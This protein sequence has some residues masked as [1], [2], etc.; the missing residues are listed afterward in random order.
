M[1]IPDYGENVYNIVSDIVGLKFKAQI[2]GSGIALKGIYKI[3]NLENQNEY[4]LLRINDTSIC[5]TNQEDFINE[6]ISLL[7]INLED[8]NSQYQDL[9]ERRATEGFVDEYAIFLE[10]EYIGV[11]GSKQET[12]LKKMRQFQQAIKLKDQSE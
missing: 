3:L 6:F 10:N 4:Y 11:C 1:I 12:L 9:N 2:K 7:K 8:L 5:F